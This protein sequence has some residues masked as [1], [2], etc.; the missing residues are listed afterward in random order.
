MWDWVDIVTGGTGG[1]LG[2]PAG[3]NPADFEMLLFTGDIFKNTNM[4]IKLN[5]C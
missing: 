5:W 2:G 4:N 1:G 3:G